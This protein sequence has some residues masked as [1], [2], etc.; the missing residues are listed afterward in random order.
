MTE[1]FRVIHRVVPYQHEDILG[2]LHRVAAKN[3]IDGIKGILLDALGTGQN[4]ITLSALPKLATYCRLY[5]EEAAQLSGIERRLADGTKVWQVCDQWVS[6]PS[7][8]ALN[9]PKVCTD[10]LREAPYARPFWAMSLYTACVDHGSVLIEACPQCSRRLQW[11]RRLF[12]YCP[13]GF[14]LAMHKASRGADDSLAMAYLI[15]L[16]GPDRPHLL[17]QTRVQEREL[18]LLASLSLDGLCKTIW[19]LGHCLAALGSY[20]TGHGKR[21]PAVRTAE[22]IV[23]AA[24]SLLRNWPANLGESLSQC[25][26]RPPADYQGG[27]VG[28]ILGPVQSYL[29]RELQGEEFK[30]VRLAYEQQLNMAWRIFGKQHRLRRNR[31]L[32]LDFGN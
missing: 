22:S 9:Q 10:C 18:Q 12:E 4:N 32:E 25:A 30:F 7:F 23:F 26:K 21:K 6:K 17:V 11:N 14:E 24:F 16:H 31:Q 27:L 28:R 8:I 2:Y 5:A 3:R 29:S 1:D 20:G 13:C 19:F 15:A